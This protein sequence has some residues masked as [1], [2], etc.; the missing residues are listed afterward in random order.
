MDYRR[1]LEEWL[2]RHP[3]QPKEES[4]EGVDPRQGAAQRRRE[5]HRMQPQG[6]LDLHGLTVE[7][8]TLRADQFLRSAHARGLSKVLIIHGKGNHSEGGK[9]V[10]KGSIRDFLASHPLA[11][12]TGVPQREQGGEGAVWVILR[13]RGYRSR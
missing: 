2:R 6:R 1:Q 7:E 8:A 13:S 3:P 4:A 11:G 10:L 5:L 12:E 9:G